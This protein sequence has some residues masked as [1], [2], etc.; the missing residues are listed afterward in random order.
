MN[1]LAQF[2]RQPVQQRI[3]LRMPGDF[4]R[5]GGLRDI[6]VGSVAFNDAQR[7]WTGV[8]AVI[9]LGSIRHPGVR[10]AIVRKIVAPRRAIRTGSDGAGC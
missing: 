5:L 9:S 4:S 7:R 2:R 8:L 1:S 10:A 6:D 3:D